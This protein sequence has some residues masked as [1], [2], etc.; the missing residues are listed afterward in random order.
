LRRFNINKHTHKAIFADFFVE[1][2]SQAA[3]ANIIL[4]SGT[5]STIAFFLFPDF[6]GT[7]KATLVLLSASIGF[8]CYFIADRIHASEKKKQTDASLANLPAYKP[9]DDDRA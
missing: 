2:D 6:S 1:A 7:L 3:F 8:V 9:L 4:Q 5:S